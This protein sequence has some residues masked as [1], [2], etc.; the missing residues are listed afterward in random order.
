MAQVMLDRKYSSSGREMDSSSSEDSDA[1]TSSD[2]SIG[3]SAEELQK[4]LTQVPDG[5]VYVRFSFTT[6]GFISQLQQDYVEYIPIVYEA[7][8]V[9]I[10]LSEAEKIQKKAEYRKAYNQRPEVVAKHQLARNDPVKI[11]ERKAYAKREDVKKRK[12]QLAQ[13]K[14]DYLRQLKQNPD[15]SYKAF[16]KSVVPPLPRKKKN[17]NIIV[18]GNDKEENAGK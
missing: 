16:I 10:K 11:A 14:R 18:D 1:P 17:Q 8:R 7:S 3:F 6:P 4:F 15:S 9:V 2:D 12:A 13:A 5:T